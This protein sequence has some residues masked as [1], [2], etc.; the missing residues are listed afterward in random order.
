MNY[1]R[2]PFAGRLQKPEP[3]AV[4]KRDEKRQQ[5]R[6]A[7]AVR[8][9]VRERDRYRCRACGTQG[10]SYNPVDVHHLKL[11]SAG[12]GDTTSNLLCL[13]RVDHALTHAYRLFIVG[14][15]ANGELR[16]E[17]EPHTL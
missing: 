3:R 11:R 10:D 12:G 7:L 6:E 1:F 17:R 16:F 15:D 14:E 2:P 13:C 4:T 8:N 5:E 9:L